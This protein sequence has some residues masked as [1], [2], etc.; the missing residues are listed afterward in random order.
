ME[1]AD[2]GADG[3][4]HSMPFVVRMWNSP[5]RHSWSYF[6]M[7][8]ATSTAGCSGAELMPMRSKY[9]A[10][11]V[12]TCSLS[13]SPLLLRAMIGLLV[14]RR[15]RASARATHPPP[16]LHQGCLSVTSGHRPQ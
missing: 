4:T 16:G 7:A 6:S 15:S 9:V 13:T 3:L 8:P 2:A 14:A 10:T 11:S 12:R 1:V 5:V